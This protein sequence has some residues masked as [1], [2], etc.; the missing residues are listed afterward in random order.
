MAGQRH[1]GCRRGG[2]QRSPRRGPEVAEMPYKG[3]SYQAIAGH[4]QINATVIQD[5]LSRQEH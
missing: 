3:S 4:S 1:E 2:W 5:F